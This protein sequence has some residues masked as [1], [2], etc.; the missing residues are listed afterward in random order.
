VWVN[1]NAVIAYGLARYGY[2]DD[3]L[4]VCFLHQFVSF[5]LAFRGENT[6]HAGWRLDKIAFSRPQIANRM[7][8]TL[9]RDLIETGTW[10]EC[11]HGDTGAGLAA[12]GFL[13]WNTLGATLLRNI[14]ARIDPFDL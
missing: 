14:R 1:A 11:Y 5:A 6:S 13:S 7:T 4:A 9:A 8:E 2:V 3:A 12:G 10:H